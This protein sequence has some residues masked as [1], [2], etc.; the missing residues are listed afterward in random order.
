MCRLTP[1]I[2]SMPIKDR[3]IVGASDKIE[4]MPITQLAEQ[5]IST[6]KPSSSTQ[7][8]PH[9]IK[10]RTLDGS[11]DVRGARREPKGW[12]VLKCVPELYQR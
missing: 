10:V 6:M 11:K 8:G 4:R 7:A 3:T 2:L 9:S 1:V 12:V 5:L